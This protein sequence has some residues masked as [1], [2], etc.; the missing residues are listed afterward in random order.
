MYTKATKREKLDFERKFEREW[1]RVFSF[2]RR[3]HMEAV[4]TGK[5]K[6]RAH[7]EDEVLR[8][9]FYGSVPPGKSFDVFCSVPYDPNPGCLRPLS[10]TEYVEHLRRMSDKALESKKPG[11]VNMDYFSSLTG[12]ACEETDPYACRMIDNSKKPTSSDPP[13]AEHLGE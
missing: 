3:K 5:E 8:G 10:A 1:T 4:Q 9:N 6:E 12:G 7:S 11:C 2:D 13:P